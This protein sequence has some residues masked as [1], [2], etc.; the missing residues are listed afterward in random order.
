MTNDNVHENVEK[1][2]MTERVQA[3]LDRVDFSQ[4]QDVLIVGV[5]PNGMLDPQPSI[6][7][8]P[9]VHWI[10]NKVVN[11]LWMMERSETEARLRAA[12]MQGENIV[13]ESDD[14]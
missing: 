13:M 11:E 8:Y 14:E 6:S 12:E 9:W 2:E 1:L 5:L 7:Q 3:V 4:Y 10:V